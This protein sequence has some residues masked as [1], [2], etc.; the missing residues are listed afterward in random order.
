MREGKKDRGR[1]MDSP[2]SHSLADRERITMRSLA[3][4]CSS[5]LFVLLYDQSLLLT[6][7]FAFLLVRSSVCPPVHPIVS[8]SASCHS[9]RQPPDASL[10]SGIHL[11]S[12]PVLPC[13]PLLLL[14]LPSLSRSLTPSHSCTLALFLHSSS[15]SAC[16]FP[17]S[18]L[19]SRSIPRGVLL[20]VTSRIARYYISYYLRNRLANLRSL[21]SY[22]STF[23]LRL[24]AYLPTIKHKRGGDSAY[25]E[26]SL[27]S[28]YPANELS[29]RG[30]S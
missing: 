22:S 6:A 4:L 23:F 25:K 15:C 5:S 11:L 13:P 29:S 12:C 7:P 21:S 20:V 14:F 10:A 19:P 18:S 9:T 28:I 24:V 8:S 30:S 3:L 2:V 1:R 27:I 16:Q 26:K 17:C